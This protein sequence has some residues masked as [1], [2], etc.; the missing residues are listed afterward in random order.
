MGWNE[1]YRI[2]ESQVVSLYDKG[3]LN[4]DVL[5]ILMQPFCNKDIDHGGSEDLRS[6]D[7][8]S[9]D[10][11]ICF[12]MEPEK[13]KAATENFVPDPEEPDYNE[14]LYDLYYEITRREWNFW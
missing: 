12:I 1:G 7:G 3:L 9:A 14:K 10:D 8:K 13:Y 4:K 11:I 2:M 6:R 5:N